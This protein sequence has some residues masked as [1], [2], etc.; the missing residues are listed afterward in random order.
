MTPFVIEERWEEQSVLGDQ[1]FPSLAS[2]QQD[3]LHSLAADLAET[4]R[5]LIAQG[6]LTVENGRVIAKGE[7]T[8]PATALHPQPPRASQSN[9]SASTM[10]TFFS[11]EG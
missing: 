7:A 1:T 10:L 9:G 8:T 11:N 6:I 5:S 3:A 4:L 2:A